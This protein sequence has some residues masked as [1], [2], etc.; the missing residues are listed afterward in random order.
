MESAP[1][2][3]AGNRA[4]SFKKTFCALC[5]F[6]WLNLLHFV[7]HLHGSRLNYFGVDATQT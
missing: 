3:F 6:L 7:T 5:A 1:I 2:S 4:L